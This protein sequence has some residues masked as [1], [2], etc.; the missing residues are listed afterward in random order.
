MLPILIFIALL[1]RSI[2]ISKKLFLCSSCNGTWTGSMTL[3][4]L[5]I[6]SE[7]MRSI[8]L[9][10]CDICSKVKHDAFSFLLHIGSPRCKIPI[11]SSQCFI[12]N[13]LTGP[14]W[15]INGMGIINAI[16]F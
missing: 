13:N 1:L 10:D 16:S 12:A 6:W 11:G 9:S 7:Y 14:W 5:M 2:L 8:D 3:E 4:C 15:R